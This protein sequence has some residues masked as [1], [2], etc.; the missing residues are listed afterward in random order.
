MNNVR[1]P[2]KTESYHFVIVSRLIKHLA[3]PPTKWVQEAVYP[4]IN[5]SE[6]E[7]KHSLSRTVRLEVCEAVSPVPL[8]LHG[9]VLNLT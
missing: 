4:G 1:F 2:I 6:S 3:K 7:S 8:S 5:R 9:V